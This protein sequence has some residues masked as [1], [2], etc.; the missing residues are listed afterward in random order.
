MTVCSEGI[1]FMSKGTATSILIGLLAAGVFRLAWA[2]RDG[3]GYGDAIGI[4]L[5]SIALLG[6]IYLIFSRAEK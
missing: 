1:I 2:W 6:F 3:A 5:T 4:T